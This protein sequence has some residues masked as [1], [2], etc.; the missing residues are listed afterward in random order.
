MAAA[1]P[2]HRIRGE[3]NPAAGAGFSIGGSFAYFDS[4]TV[5]LTYTW[6]RS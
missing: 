1:M 4:G 3:K 6:S 2:R 5:N